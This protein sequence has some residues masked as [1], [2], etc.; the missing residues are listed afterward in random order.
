MARMR[1]GVA[2]ALL[3]GASLAPL[4]TTAEAA[5]CQVFEDLMT[6]TSVSENYLGYLQSG[7]APDTA[8]QMERVIAGT[9]RRELHN[10]LRTGNMGQLTRDTDGLLA[11]QNTLLQIDR[12][13]GRQA[14][15]QTSQRMNADGNLAAYRQALT[16]TACYNENQL[17]GVTTVVGQLPSIGGVPAGTATA[18][19]LGLVVLAILAFIAT[20]R[21]TCMLN[22]RRKRYT[23]ALECTLHDGGVAT[24]AAILDIS[25]EG[26][27]I[28]AHCNSQVGAKITLEMPDGVDPA[29]LEGRI[30]WVNADHFGIKFSRILSRTEVE[31]IAENELSEVFDPYAPDPDPAMIASD[32]ANMDKGEQGARRH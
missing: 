27:K 19:A 30:L 24:E 2:A 26:A 16:L 6:L 13:Q 15:L 22:A 8:Q 1:R 17:Q 14:A 5:D 20:E 31:A 7:F 4:A 28:E 9:S 21:R 3:A 10:G 11:Q 23:C 29:R 32:G 18:G 12:S 25:Q